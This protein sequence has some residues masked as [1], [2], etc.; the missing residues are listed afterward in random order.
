MTGTART[1][2]KRYGILFGILVA[3]FALFFSFSYLRKKTEVKYLTAAADALCNSYPAFKGL[4]VAVTGTAKNVPAGMA[5]R[6]VFSASYAGHDALIFFL[7]LT[8]KYGVYPAVFF[9]EP[10][11][12]CIFCGLAGVNVPFDQA[13][14]Y[15]I[16]QAAVEL[17]RRKIETLMQGRIR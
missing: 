9:Y 1:A 16:T 17:S 13:E 14:R 15:G 11:L 7:S 2:L 12:G 10:S 6:A 4:T 5:F 8:G 3:V